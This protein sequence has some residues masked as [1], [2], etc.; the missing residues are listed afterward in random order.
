MREGESAQCKTCGGVSRLG[1]LADAKSVS[2][3]VLERANG[4]IGYCPN[5]GHAVYV[6]DVL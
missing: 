5:C 6:R 1:E 4:F 2:G 3:E